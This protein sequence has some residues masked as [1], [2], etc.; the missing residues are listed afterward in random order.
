[1]GLTAWIIDD[2]CL[3]FQMMSPFGLSWIFLFIFLLLNSI[4]KIDCDV[5][6]E[7]EIDPKLLE[8][9]FTNE[10]IVAEGQDPTQCSD[11][12]LQERAR[13]AS[14]VNGTLISLGVES[15]VGLGVALLIFLS[16][17]VFAAG[18]AQAFQLVS[19]SKNPTFTRLSRPS[20]SLFF[21]IKQIL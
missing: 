20:K 4:Q 16:V 19:I 13:R 18:I 7:D 5:V 10:L 9:Y 8:K 3:I 11:R 14:N 2:T 21:K 17:G 6:K 12:V 15:S 1:M